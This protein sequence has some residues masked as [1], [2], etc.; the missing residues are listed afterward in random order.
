MFL[1]EF[2]TV[3]IQIFSQLVTKINSCGSMDAMQVKLPILSNTCKKDKKGHDLDRK[4]GFF[5]NQTSF[6]DL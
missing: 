5:V 2:S 3:I 6:F 4:N 1:N